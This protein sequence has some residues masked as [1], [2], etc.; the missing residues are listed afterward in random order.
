MTPEQHLYRNMHDSV[1]KDV[2]DKTDTPFATVH[3]NWFRRGQKH[4]YKGKDLKI[5]CEQPLLI[6][7]Y[8][9]VGDGRLLRISNHPKQNG[10]PRGII[11]CVYD[12][13]TGKIDNK[14]LKNVKKTL[15]I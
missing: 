3:T 15:D 8:V 5:E 4:R 1:V 7:S 9:E 11:D 14:V 10:V 6:S 2:L 12:W 13:Q